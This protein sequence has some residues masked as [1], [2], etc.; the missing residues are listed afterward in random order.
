MTSLPTV[1]SNGMN[2]MNNIEIDQ[3]KSVNN[4][5]GT[6]ATKSV[7]SIYIKPS[8]EINGNN[9]TNMNT[10]QNTNANDASIPMGNIIFN[11][12]FYTSIY[13][14]FSYSSLTKTLHLKILQ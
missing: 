11:H 3:E 1:V 2:A 9:T 10:V 5:N 12:I 14:V 13:L 7:I 6:D 8:S 4:A